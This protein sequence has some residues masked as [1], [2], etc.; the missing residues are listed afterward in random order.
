MVPAIADRTAAPQNIAPQRRYVTGV[1]F[2]VGVFNLMDRQM[3]AVLIEP[4]RRDLHLSD[5]LMGTLTGFAFVAFYTVASVPIARLAEVADR[6][7]I[8]SVA[9]ALWSVM[10]GLAALASSFAQLALT[11]IGVG[12]GESASNPASQSMLADL[13]PLQKR[14]LAFSVLA[15]ASPV[16]LMLAFIIGGWLSELVGWRMTLVW[17]GAPGLLLAIIVWTA[18]REPQ[19]GAAE[20]GSPDTAHY[21]LRTTLRYLLKARSFGWLTLGASLSVFTSIAMIVWSTSFLTRLHALPA[22]RAGLWLGLATGCGGVIG[23]P[24]SGWLASRL[25]SRD[26]AWLLRLPALTSALAAP[27]VGL[28]LSLA[29]PETALLFFFLAVV[30][31]TAMMGPVSTAVQAIAKVRMRATAAAIVLLA[32]NFIGTGFGPLAVGLASD[33]LA[34][35]LGTGSIRLALGLAVLASVAAGVFFYMG[36]RHLRTDIHRAAQ[37]LFE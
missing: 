1:L 37:P 14:V 35:A 26:I 12:I 5:T 6:R 23:S 15:T 28:F 3:L 24:L 36:A 4:I 2:L 11:R 22:P 18:V 7:R 31:S 29:G 25:S 16:G 34:P 8:I 20:S 32:F 19:R 17:A 30:F 13:Y 9:L 10:T 27:C 21:D 33:L